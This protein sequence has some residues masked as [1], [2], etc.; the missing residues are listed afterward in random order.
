[1]GSIS[2]TIFSILLGWIKGLV[3]MIW[4]SFTG[5]EGE[6]F[7]QFIGKN[8]IIITVIICSV[9]LVA[10]F[11]VYL[12]RWEPY[13]V[14]RTFWRKLRGKNRNDAGEEPA[15]VRDP[16]PAGE[17]ERETVEIP[18]APAAQPI[19]EDAPDEDDEFYRWREREEVYPDPRDTVPVPEPE[20][21][22]AGYVVPADSPYRRPGTT[23]E[24]DMRD[25]GYGEP[26]PRRRRRFSAILGDS[27]EEE[28]YR[29]FAPKPIVNEKDAYRDP[30]Y[31]EKWNGKQES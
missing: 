13:K 29:Y 12:F 20:V 4:A 22:R 31:P 8:W 16:I 24:E 30:V 7:L 27:G 28:P 25:S 19:P 14:W 3:S 5:K 6:T 10:D 11:V 9:G 15:E 2:N 26:A 17:T 18:V 1:M 21:T 23:R